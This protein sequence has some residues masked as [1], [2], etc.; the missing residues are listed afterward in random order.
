MTSLR[1][2][3]FDAPSSARGV[4]AIDT[5]RRR[6]LDELAGRTVWFASALVGGRSR[7]QSLRERLGRTVEGV[8]TGWMEV[9][10]DEPLRGLTQR[11]DAMLSGGPRGA[12]RL[13]PADRDAYAEG[14]RDHESLMRD[15]VRADDV[16]VL[17]DPLTAALARAVRERGAHAIWH[18]SLAPVSGGARLEEARLVMGRHAAGLDAFVLT[19][20]RRVGRRVRAQSVAALMPCADMVTA[21]ETSSVPEAAEGGVQELGW[22]SMLAD[23]VHADRGDTVGGTLHPR[24]SVAAR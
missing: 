21:K 7:A 18:V 13:G 23:V 12:V 1:I 20:Q 2:D 17:H 4:R 5:A 22:Y 16:V 14:V 8:S 11:L 6:A 19:W 24:P 3:H 15:D 9:A 10:A